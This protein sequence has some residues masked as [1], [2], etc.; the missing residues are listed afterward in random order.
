M[1]YLIGF[2]IGVAVTTVVA[3]IWRDIHEKNKINHYKY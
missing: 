3:L 2:I 1:E